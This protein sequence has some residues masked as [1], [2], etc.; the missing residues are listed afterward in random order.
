MDINV[1]SGIG[2]SMREVI[3]LL[4]NQSGN[5]LRIEYLPRR[6][7]DPRKVI[8]DPSTFLKLVDNTELLRVADIAA[9]T[10]R[11]HIKL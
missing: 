10:W 8:G 11:A 2:T 7:E 6:E 4:E 3:K 9:S 1:C 5:S